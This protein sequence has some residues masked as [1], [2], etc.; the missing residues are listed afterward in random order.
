MEKLFVRLMAT[1]LGAGKIPFAPGTAGTLLGIPLFIIFSRMSWQLH[2]LSIVALSFLAAYVSGEMEKIL[3]SKDAPSIVID[4]IVGY[5]FTMFLITPTPLC[6]A[7][8]FI[9]FR[10]FDIVKPFP[11]GL[12]EKKIP[13]G[14]GVVADDIVAGAYG[15]IV[16][17]LGIFIQGA[18]IR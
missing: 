1:G 10:I 7:S 2:M 6:I 16:L 17:T 4:E 12:C 13:G 18:Y 8:G 14:W 9:A 11:I 5:Q 15:H 3:G